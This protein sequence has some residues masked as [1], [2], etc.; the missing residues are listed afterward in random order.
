MMIKMTVKTVHQVNTVTMG[1]TV[2]HATR[3]PSQ[4]ATRARVD[5]AQPA[6]DQMGMECVK[7]AMRA[8]HRMQINSTVC[9]VPTTRQVLEDSAHSVALGRSQTQVK[10]HAFHVLAAGLG[11]RENAVFVHQDSIQTMHVLHV[12][13]AQTDKRERWGYARPVHRARSH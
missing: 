13:H 4:T 10:Q 12:K 5:P 2:F 3:V 11:L 8:K 1:V 7:H 6:P 9:N